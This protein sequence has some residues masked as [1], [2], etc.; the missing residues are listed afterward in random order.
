MWNLSLLFDEEDS[1]LNCA[2]TQILKSKNADSNV[3]C[4]IR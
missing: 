3:G 1:G 4:I 2:V